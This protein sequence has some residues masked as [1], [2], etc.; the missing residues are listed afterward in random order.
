MPARSGMMEEGYYGF[1]RYR[2]VRRYGRLRCDRHGVPAY[3]GISPQTLDPYAV[4]RVLDRMARQEEEVQQ[5]LVS[6][7]LSASEEDAAPTFFYDLTSTCVDGTTSPLAKPGYSRDHRP[8]RTQIVIGLLITDTWYPIYWQV[9]PG[10][11]TDVTTIQT[12]VTDLRQ[13][14]KVGSC[15]MVFDRGMVSEAN[16]QIIEADHHTF[17]S[18]L[19]RDSLPGLPFW[20]TAWP[21]TIPQADWQTVV[22]QRGLQAYDEDATLWFREWSHQGR[23]LVLAFDHQRF[24]L[25]MAVQTAA[26]AAV[27]AWVQAKNTDLA[28]AQ[29]SRQAAPIERDLRNLLRRKHLTGIVQTMTDDAAGAIAAQ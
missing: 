9:W 27:Q 18:T 22:A 14:L 13:R 23:R 6:Q 8:D 7:Y 12:V 19:D 10:N 4:H 17:L 24:G 1:R 15:I 20:T 16:L 5:W 21:E 25:E 28:S 26:I 11:T 3:H 2:N 29:R